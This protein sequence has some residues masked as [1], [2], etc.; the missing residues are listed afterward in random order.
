NRQARSWREKL[1]VIAA[2]LTRHPAGLS[3]QHLVEVAIYVRFLS[4][5]E[6]SCV[7][8]GRHFRPAHHARLAS[9]IFHRLAEI[10]TE[11]N[12]FVLRRI[13]PA[14]PSFDASF[15]QA[16]PLTRIR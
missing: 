6:I 16:E 4:T 10:A 2:V 3:L 13:Y 12:E 1:E 11:K 15:R 7:E 14:L 9:D 5:G 8:D